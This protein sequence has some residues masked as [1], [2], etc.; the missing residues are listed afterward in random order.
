MM[1]SVVIPA[2]NEEGCIR[3]TLSALSEKLRAE[4]ISHEILVINDNSSDETENILRSLQV[5]MPEL[6]YINNPPPNGFGFAVRCGLE[7]FNG[8]AVAV[9]MAD[10]SDR[11]EDLVKFYRTMVNDDVDCVFGSRF[12]PESK[13]IDYPWPKLIL[14]RMANSFIQAL[15]GLRYNDVTNAFK[16]YRK[17]VI[18]GLQ[19]LLSHHFNLTVELPLK[20]IVRGYTFSVVPNDWINRKAGESKLKIK[21]MGSRYLFITLYCLLEKWLSR[22]DYHR[23]N[24]RISSSTQR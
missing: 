6:R 14:N 5:N 21:E 10:A 11:P 22:G 23:K 18:D 13:I 19:P 12:T 15:F 17:T 24:S 4:K 16:M 20:A 7:N 8:D 3:G 2:H 9:Y 1:L